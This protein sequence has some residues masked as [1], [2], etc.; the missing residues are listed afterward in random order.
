[1][2]RFHEKLAREIL[3][4]LTDSQALFILFGLTESRATT[5]PPLFELYISGKVFT[6]EKVTD[7]I[8]FGRWRSAAASLLHPLLQVVPRVLRSFDG[9]E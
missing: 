7:A 2:T 9:G 5:P 8:Y 1:M 3:S 6:Y 4:P